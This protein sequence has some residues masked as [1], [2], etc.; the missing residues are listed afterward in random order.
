M[1]TTKFYSFSIYGIVFCVLMDCTYT[2]THKI[3]E[4]NLVFMRNSAQRE[5]FNFYFFKGFLL[6]LTKL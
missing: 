5:K 6:V 1:A 4:T 2:I 3:S